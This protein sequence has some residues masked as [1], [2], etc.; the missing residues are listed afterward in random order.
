[1]TR[2]LLLMRHAKSS[3]ASAELSDHG[4]PLNARGRA[5][6]TGMAVLLRQRGLQPD[7]VFHSTAARTT[8]TW[9]RMREEL[10]PVSQVHAC[11]SLYLAGADA[12]CD[13]LA[14]LP[15]TVQTVLVLGHNPGW[16]RAVETYSGHVLAM[17]TAD[18][19]VLMAPHGEWVD[20]M[21]RAS[22]WT[23]VE[24]IRGRDALDR[25]SIGPPRSH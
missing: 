18:V 13:A 9:H 14:P 5:T 21:S 23:Y 19:A 12:L 17:K 15:S 16:E 6:A 1:M 4:R 2:R 20:L 25:S 22:M 3:W 8:E 7:R 24:T 11:D 10:P